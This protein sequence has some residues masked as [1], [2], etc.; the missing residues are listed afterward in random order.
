M[1]RGVFDTGAI[2][3]LNSFYDH[4]ETTHEISVIKQHIPKQV[5]CSAI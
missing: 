4:F 1:K 3:V 5:I 2:E